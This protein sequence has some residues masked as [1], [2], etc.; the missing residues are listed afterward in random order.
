MKST[1]NHTAS[2][3]RRIL[4]KLVLLLLL[5]G[6]QKGFSQSAKDTSKIQQLRIYEIFEHNKAAF[7]ERF[8]KHAHRIM[9]KY[10]FHII[11]FW[12]AK[13]SAKT[14]FVYLLEW[15]DVK[16]LK[17]SWAKFMADEEWKE[18][19]RQTAKLHGQMV[20]DI[21]DRILT[22]LP[23]SPVKSFEDK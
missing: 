20:G 4:P 9:K 12:E 14:E 15:P 11:S 1:D 22:P 13:D 8:G 16:T 19:K 18:I 21:Q 17:E 3:I 6:L 5:A 2:L 23:Y 7:H 10:G